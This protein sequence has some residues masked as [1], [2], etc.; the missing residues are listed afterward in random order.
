MK[1]RCGQLETD[2]RLPP[3]S[4]HLAL[5]P[6]HPPSPCHPKGSVMKAAVL[7]KIGSPLSVEEV[8][9]P[10]IGA[11]EVLIETR[12]CGICRT[13]LHIQDGL[14]YVPGLPHIPGHEPA[15][16][17]VDMGRDVS[18]IRV[19]QRVVPHLFVRSAECRY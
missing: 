8:P 5:S 2:E 10:S 16:V 17:V 1:P 18:G 11:D 6:C 9:T 4:H 12:T 14:A 3:F 13:D 7:K 19:G 15:G